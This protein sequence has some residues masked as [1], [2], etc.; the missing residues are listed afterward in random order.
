MT[1]WWCGAPRGN[2]WLVST[3]SVSLQI[4]SIRSWFGGGEWN[5]ARPAAADGGEQWRRLGDDPRWRS[6]GSLDAQKCGRRSR[7]RGEVV[8]V[9]FVVSRFL[10]RCQAAARGA[11]VA[12][13]SSGLGHSLQ[14]SCRDDIRS[15]RAVLQCEELGRKKRGRGLREPR[16]RAPAFFNS[17]EIRTHWFS[18]FRARKFSKSSRGEE[19]VHM[20]RWR[21]AGVT[22]SSGFH[23]ILS[24]FD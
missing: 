1:W 20:G 18:S 15:G 17:G 8:G 21:G 13:N 10:E 14:C 5:L 7:R 2:T 3:A 6:R 16:V 22:D 23:G 11:Q 4:C 12:V 19:G 24:R 9:L